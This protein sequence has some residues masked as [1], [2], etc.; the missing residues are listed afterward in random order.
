MVIGYG[1]PTSGQYESA[2]SILV[3]SVR[4]AIGSDPSSRT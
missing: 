3:D 2:L 4:T 1:A